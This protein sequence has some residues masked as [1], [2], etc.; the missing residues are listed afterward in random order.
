MGAT[1]PET[2][3]SI[4]G[5]GDLDVTCRSVW[6]RNRR[7]GREIVL[8]GLIERCASIDEVIAAMPRFGYLAEGVVTAKHVHTLCAQ[9]QI[10]LPI[11][12][13]VYRVL[14][15]EADPHDEVGNMLDRIAG[16]TRAA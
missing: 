12:T 7:F 10:V 14:N 5:V 8:K 4:A 2:F 6:G 9:K 11:S 13:S 15:R 1:H 3:T 16:Q